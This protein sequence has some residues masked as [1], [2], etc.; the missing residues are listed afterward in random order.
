MVSFPPQM[1]N[2]PPH[3]QDSFEQA[4]A[5]NRAA[6]DGKTG[7]ELGSTVCDRLGGLRHG[8][9][10][11]SGHIF[12]SR[13]CQRSSVVAARGGGQVA[14]NVVIGTM[15][16]DGDVAGQVQGDGDGDHGEEEEK[17]RICDISVSLV[18]ADWPDW[19]LERLTED[20]LFG[21]RQHVEC[22][23]DFVLISL[24]LEPP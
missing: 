15:G 1:H 14:G 12:G 24:A 4:H 6:Q 8:G 10:R 16:D 7:L 3:F 9:R 13:F 18:R 17:N 21:R 5:T 2:L 19:G 22:K 20:E 11:G 23:G